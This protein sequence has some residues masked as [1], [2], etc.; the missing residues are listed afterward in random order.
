MC[1]WASGEQLLQTVT[2]GGRPFLHVAGYRRDH[3]RVVPK[4]GHRRIQIF[5]A[6]G[7]AQ[8]PVKILGFCQLAFGKGLVMNSFAHTI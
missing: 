7:V 2:H 3:V 1:T 6:Y 8:P 5:P 4:A